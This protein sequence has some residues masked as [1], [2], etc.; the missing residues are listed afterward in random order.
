MKSERNVETVHDDQIDIPVAEDNQVDIVQEPR[1]LTA[2]SSKKVRRKT[3]TTDPVLV[4]EQLQSPQRIEPEQHNNN[5]PV[6]RGVRIRKQPDRLG[7]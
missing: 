4:Q 5:T 6:R 3:K 7:F 1:P 2:P